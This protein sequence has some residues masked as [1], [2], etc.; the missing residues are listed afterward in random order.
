MP[1]LL[2]DIDADA[3][4]LWNELDNTVPDIDFD[5]LWDYAFESEDP[6]VAAPEVG[7]GSSVAASGVVLEVILAPDV[8][9]VTPV[10]IP[11]QALLE[12]R[13][14]PIPDAASLNHQC[15]KRVAAHEL[16]PYHEEVILKRQK[17]V[18]S[19]ANRRK[20]LNECVDELAELTDQKPGKNRAGVLQNVVVA[21][22]DFRLPTQQVQTRQISQ[23]GCAADVRIDRNSVDPVQ[24][25]GALLAGQDFQ[26]ND[27]NHF[28]LRRL[29]SIVH[30]ATRS[31]PRLIV[32][33]VGLT[34]CHTEQGELSC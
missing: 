3:N 21:I 4:Q 23:M 27:I 22:R 30:T 13:T 14:M 17:N 9:P 32:T 6:L 33:L 19:E 34:H 12:I 31:V 15:R 2:A 24:P 18:H 10:V 26:I 28:L 25:V 1:Q 8:P 7:G 29:V 16:S 11:A 20:Q 5:D